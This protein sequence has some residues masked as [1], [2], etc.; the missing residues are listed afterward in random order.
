MIE[1][2]RFPVGKHHRGAR[3]D[4]FL[5]TV[6]QEG[7]DR[8][9]SRR[10]IRRIIS[11][12][13]VQVNGQRVKIQS[14]TLQIGQ[15]VTVAL[16]LGAAARVEA[17]VQELRREQILYLDRYLIAVD[18]P[19]G[20][21]TQATRDNDLDHLFAA[22]KRWLV[23]HDRSGNRSRGAGGRPEPYLALH[24]RLDRGTSGVVLMS[25]S[26]LA[27]R[28]LA[29]S[30][31]G[32]LV[33]KIYFALVIDASGAFPGAPWSV[34]NRLTEEISRGRRLGYSVPEE[35]LSNERASGPD[36][37]P[38]ETAFRLLQRGNGLAWV[39]AQ[40]KTGR[41][42]QVRIHLSEAGFPVLGDRLYGSVASGPEPPDVRLMLHA[43]VLEL[44]HPVTGENLRLESPVPN[45]F[46]K[47]LEQR[48][49]EGLAAELRQAE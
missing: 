6:L 47:I 30:F 4:L 45:D 24:H 44:E 25:K 33:R 7:L 23:H 18:K 41:T 39:E 10:E 12:G 1:S 40:P 43:S 42:H 14:R 20:L 29:R 31:A 2:L 11:R 22:T 36:G 5:A 34:R 3:L 28:G 37:R 19:S 35:E 49:S 8:P 13:G 32:S 16:D 21:P 46:R 27:N 15:E 26:R 48:F 38:A 17:E 9:V